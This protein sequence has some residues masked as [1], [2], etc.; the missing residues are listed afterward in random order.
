MNH[1]PLKGSNTS[2]DSLLPKEVAEKYE[3]VGWKFGPLIHYPKVRHLGKP[4][5]RVCLTDMDLAYAAKLVAAKF[6]YLKEKEPKAE[7][8]GKAE[9]QK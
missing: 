8:P 7:K 4:N 5:G 3:T 9:A 2:P 6:P 1:Q